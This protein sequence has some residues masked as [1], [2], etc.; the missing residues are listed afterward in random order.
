MESKE[1]LHFRKIWDP[2]VLLIDWETLRIER[3]STWGELFFDLIFVAAASKVSNLLIEEVSGKSF[4]VLLIYWSIFWFTWNKMTFFQNR[5]FC[6][7]LVHQFLFLIQMLGVLLMLHH[8]SID[9]NSHFTFSIGYLMSTGSFQ[10]MYLLIVVYIPRAR[11]NTMIQLICSLLGS[12]LILI[13]FFLNKSH[14]VIILLL[15]ILVPFCDILHFAI[16]YLKFRDQSLPVNVDHMTERQ[17]IM[18]MIVL[19]EPI[20]TVS[21]AAFDNLTRLPVYFGMGLSFCMIFCLYLIYYHLNPPTSLHAIRRGIIA[22]IIF[23]HSHLF[24]S[25]SILVFTAGLQLVIENI[26]GKMG[27]N[28]SWILCGGLSVTLILMVIIRMSHFFWRSDD[29]TKKLKA[30]LPARI[31]WWTIIWVFALLPLIFVGTNNKI[32]SLLIVALLTLFLVTCVV[33]ETFLTHRFELKHKH[34]LY[35]HLL[36]PSEERHY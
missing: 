24:L 28:T 4:I 14:E 35:E 36:Q 25:A 9:F 12:L 34:S 31:I 11:V 29:L 32:S 26:E 23:V 30:P 17:G 27:I 7:S 20:V 2:P 3:K 21:I 15:W 19:G 8:L 13:T 16:M 1:H 5:F 22:S 10:A 33:I 18:I 6:D